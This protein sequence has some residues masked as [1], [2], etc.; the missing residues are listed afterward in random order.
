[1]TVLSAGYGL[2]YQGLFAGGGTLGVDIN[3]GTAPGLN[4]FANH[5]TTLTSELNLANVKLPISERHPDGYLPIVSVFE[6]NQG[7]VAYDLNQRS[8][9]AQNFNVGLQRELMAGLT[10][11][12]RYVATKGT[13]L[14]GSININAPVLVENG[15]SNAVRTTREGGDAPLFDQM[16]SGLTFA[17]V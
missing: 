11:D 5:P 6:R 14:P 3:V 9:Y 8:P 1:N 4:H 7:G 13:K 16:L 15:L 12:V 17:G 10:L 2:N